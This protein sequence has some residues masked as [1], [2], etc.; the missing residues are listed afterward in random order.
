MAYEFIAHT[1]REGVVTV[2]LNRPEVLNSFHRP[3]STELQGALDSAGT[4]P[5]VRAILLT[6]AGRAFCAGQDLAEAAVDREPEAGGLPDLG[7]IVRDSFNPLV[8][9]IRSVEKP[10]VCAVNGVA[11]GAGANLALA[12]DILV[13]AEEAA[14]IQSFSQ[15]GLIPDTGGTYFLPRAVGFH[16]ATAMTLLGQRITAT[17]ARDW[18]M[19][20]EVVPRTSLR[21]AAEGLA[22]RL[23][24][25]ATR[26]FAL[27]KRALNQS[28]QNDLETQL[29]LEEAL[30]RE[31]GATRD[32]REGVAAFLEKREP[33]FTG[34]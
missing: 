14:F 25:G 29:R 30:Q 4:D 31:A 19:V 18:G 6:G 27:T 23:A 34:Q 24:S 22:L 20:H 26:G 5:Q 32:Y 8:R 12:C 9:R 1:F 3:M 2:T 21:E 16:R 11:A 13:A 7:E 33:E 15:V 17:Q 10:V 28:M